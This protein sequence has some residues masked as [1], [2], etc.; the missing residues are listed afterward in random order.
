MTEGQKK[1]SE[2]THAVISFSFRCIRI[3]FKPKYFKMFVII[4]LLNSL[5]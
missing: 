4:T 3:K 1:F 5:V 2:N